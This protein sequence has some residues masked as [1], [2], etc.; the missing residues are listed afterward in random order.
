MLIVTKKESASDLWAVKSCWFGEQQSGQEWSTLNSQKILK[1]HIF[2]P[3]SLWSPS[4]LC[5]YSF[6][7]QAAVNEQKT[8]FL[9]QIENACICRWH[10]IF[11][12]QGQGVSFS[13]ILLFLQQQWSSRV[14]SHY[15]SS[16]QS[17]DRTGPWNILTA[18]WNDKLC[19]N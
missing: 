6:Y 5:M 9:P 11:R 8:S 15:Q 3:S 17:E 7:L 2:I 16:S 4:K 1:W 12:F 18:E 10:D 13:A 19:A 14:C